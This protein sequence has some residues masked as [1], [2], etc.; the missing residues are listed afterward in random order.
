MGNSMSP[1]EKLRDAKREINC[2]IR[3]LE[4]QRYQQ[5]R[6]EQKTIAQIR[7]AAE[8]GQVDIAKL[9]AKNIVRSRGVS[10]QCLECISSLNVM[11]DQMDKA[12]TTNQIATV[13]AQ[14]T[15]LMGQL[16]TS[17]DVNHISAVMHQF[18]RQSDVN[19]YRAEQMDFAMSA[20]DSVD[21]VDSDA[22]VEQLLDEI[23]VDLTA[24]MAN[25]PR[26]RIQSNLSNSAT[27]IQAPQATNAYQRP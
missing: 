11:S 2:V 26:S 14:A 18:T 7:K 1:R 10:R 25:A 4:G 27:H 20:I 6:G 13:I 22:V 21:E 8:V 19:E 16:N 17:M 15:D 3:R 23:Q 9:Y 12:C 24:A 5:E